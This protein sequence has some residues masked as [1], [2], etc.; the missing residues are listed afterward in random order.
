MWTSVITALLKQV[1]T[2]PAILQ[3]ILSIVADLAAG[4]KANPQVGSDI[5]Q[6]FAPK[7]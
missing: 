5:V 2:N 3:T 6:L 4:F 1:E 7:K